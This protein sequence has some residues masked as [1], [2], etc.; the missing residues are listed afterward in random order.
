MRKKPKAK[1]D[2]D[3]PAIKMKQEILAI[4]ATD[5]R[6]SSIFGAKNGGVL[7]QKKIST[8]L[9]CEPGVGRGEKLLP[10]RYSREE[11]TLQTSA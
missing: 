4:D 8:D 7:K 11:G 3:S 9:P 10:E 5:V 1:C 2:K 6:D